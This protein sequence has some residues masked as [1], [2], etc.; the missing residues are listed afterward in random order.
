MSSASSASFAATEAIRAGD[1]DLFLPAL[2]DVVNTRI[3]AT[4]PERTP[5]MERQGQVWVW[6][7]R[8]G[9]TIKGTGVRW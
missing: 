5:D 7:R 2:E 9:W 3:H 1:W 4:E 8:V 6:L